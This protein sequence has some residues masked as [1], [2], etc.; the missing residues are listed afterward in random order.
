MVALLGEKAAFGPISAC[1]A[2][3]RAPQRRSPGL[4]VRPAT[5]RSSVSS[6]SSSYDRGS[7]DGWGA[8]GEVLGTSPLHTR[9][10]P[11]CELRALR[12]QDEDREEPV[13]QLALFGDAPDVA[14][15]ARTEPP[16]D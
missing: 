8:G 6:A 15:P 12:R 16:V 1:S 13:S 5:S 14:A 11:R 2:R 7:A 9:V 3:N 4:G 10:M